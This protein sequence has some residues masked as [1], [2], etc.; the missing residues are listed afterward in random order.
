MKT[1]TKESKIKHSRYFAMTTN[2]AA[3]RMSE[4]DLGPQEKERL[5][6]TAFASLYHWRITGTPKN[7]HLAYILVSRAL[8]VNNMGDA[9]LE[10]GLK[11]LSYF[12][13]QPDTEAWI[14]AFCY[15]IVANA[16]SALGKKRNF[17]KY[18]SQAQALAADLNE[19][20]LVFFNKTLKTISLLD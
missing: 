19:E 3:W 9:A 7:V 12:D 2:N 6:E 11:S 5:L 4:S 14:R 18:F 16:Y 8:S 10:F 1:L 15:L 17:K 20:E 13:E